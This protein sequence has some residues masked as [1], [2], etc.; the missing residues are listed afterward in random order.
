MRLIEMTRESGC[1]S[2]SQPCM[3]AGVSVGIAETLMFTANACI[4]KHPARP[5]SAIRVSGG[6]PA[7]KKERICPA[8]LSPFPPRAPLHRTQVFPR[9][10][11]FRALYPLR[12]RSAPCA[13]NLAKPSFNAPR[14]MSSGPKTAVVSRITCYRSLQEKA[15][16]RSSKSAV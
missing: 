12:D 13:V 9:P 2:N 8:Y 3:E 1:C 4:V 11:P 5:Q 7:S 16:G 6:Y 10:Y 15:W 14:A